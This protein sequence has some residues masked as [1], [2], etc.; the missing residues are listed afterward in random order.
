MDALNAPTAPAAFSTTISSAGWAP[1]SSSSAVFRPAQPGEW[2]N[3]WKI[4]SSEVRRHAARASDMAGGASGKDM[5]RSTSEICGPDEP[6]RFKMAQYSGVW[7]SREDSYRGCQ[8]V[9]GGTDIDRR[10]A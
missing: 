2:R 5:R 4:V 9:S 8:P 10:L 7:P 6:E 1:R 3:R